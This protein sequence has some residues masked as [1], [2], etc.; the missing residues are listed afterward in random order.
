MM[1]DTQGDMTQFQC[2]PVHRVTLSSFEITMNENNSR[3]IPMFLLKP[4]TYYSDNMGTTTIQPGRPVVFHFMADAK[5]FLRKW[6]ERDFPTEAEWGICFKRRKSDKNIPGVI[7][8]H[9]V[10]ANFRKLHWEKEKAG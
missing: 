10:N 8:H 5:R 3:A 6:L 2:T 7:P 4:R 9:P 1:G